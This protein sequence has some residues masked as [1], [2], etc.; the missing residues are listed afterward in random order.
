[1]KFVFASYVTSADFKSPRAWLKRINGYLGILEALSAEHEVMSIEHIGYE[2]ELIHNGVNYRFRR[3]SKLGY[4]FP[5]AMHRFIK[6]QKPDVVFIQG[7]HHPLQVMQLRLLLGKKVKVMVQHHA[8]KPFTRLKK[9]LQ[10]WADSSIDA[11]LFASLGFGQEWMNAGIISS[12]HKIHEVMEVSSVFYPTDPM[13]AKAK[14]G[15]SGQPVFLW[16]GRLDT[17]KDPLNVVKA[18]L[19]FLKTCPSARVYMVYHTDELLKDLTGVLNS[20]PLGEAVTLIGKLPHDDLLYWYNSADFFISGSYYEAGGT[21]ACEAASCGC[22]P[23]LTDIFSFRTMTGNGRCGILYPAGDQ[24]ALLN[25]LLQTTGM[26]I[27]QERSKVLT[28][29]TASLS[30]KAIAGKIAD[31]AASL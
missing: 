17:N 27:A 4:Y 10:V 6:K 1:M 9:N 25:A 15:V 18:F 12:A 16:V 24:Q 26:N 19:A 14:T 8:E 3:F 23:I 2:G 20:D 13:M 11:Y 31:V 21:A 30:F 22:I 29:Y 5:L 28:Y 7:L